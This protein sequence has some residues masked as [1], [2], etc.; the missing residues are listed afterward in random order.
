MKKKLGILAAG[1]A[2]VIAIT[3]AAWAETNYPTR[4]VTV[5]VPFPPGGSTD[6]LIR[7]I[8]PRLAEK[9]GQTVIVE[10]KAGAAATIGADYVSR[11]APDGYTLLAGSA[12]HTIAQAVFPKL[13]YQ[14]NQSFAPVGTI[15]MVPN[16][17][18]VN[19]TMQAKSIDELVTAT[20]AEPDRFNYAS[21]GPGSAH[22][23]IGE[24]F[25]MRTGAELT[26]IPYGGSAPAVAGLLS[27]QVQVMFDTVPS[28]LPHIQ[29]G[30]THVLAAT[31]AARS[32]A[33]PDTPTL[34]ESGLEGFDVGTWMGLLAPAGTPD[35]IIQ[36]LNR[37]LV[38]VLNTPEVKEQLLKQGI[39]P[40]PSTSAEL[41]DRIN[42]EVNEFEALVE[43]AQLK[44]E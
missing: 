8:G 44:I 43:Q 41:T 25:K 1:F 3:P 2:S 11:S 35:S 36:R 9:L 20:K 5:V 38:D 32:S 33:L 30:R 27:N 39:E 21:A 24:M 17:V 23:L 13:N 16:L 4:A 26:H 18:V 40:M 10:N 14:V 31:T 42:R 28:A 7:L 34:A 6:V 37:E 15:A 19:N 22:H 12:H 29:S